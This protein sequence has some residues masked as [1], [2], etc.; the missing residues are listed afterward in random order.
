MVGGF[1]NLRVDQVHNV[2]KIM[3]LP[4]KV[5]HYERPSLV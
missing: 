4:S 3:L 1:K 2:S 5:D